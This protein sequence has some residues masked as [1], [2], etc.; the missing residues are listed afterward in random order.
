LLVGLA[1][2]LFLS[3]AL[4]LRAAWIDK[5]ISGLYSP[6]TLNFRTENSALP[7]K[8]KKPRIVLIG[9][10]RISQWPQ[11]LWPQSWE[12]INRGIGGET[13]AQLKA[14]FRSDALALS[15]D[16]VVVESGIN[17]LVAA[18]YLSAS[19]RAE[20]TRK[21]LDALQEFASSGA[22]ARVFVAIATIIPP[23]RPDFVRLF[24]WDDRVRASVTR[25][26]QEL[27]GV[28]HLPP[29]LDFSQL[30][31]AADDAVLPNVYRKD[32]LH[33]NAAGYSLLT[34]A[35]VRL[36]QGRLKPQREGP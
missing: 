25:V 7:L 34:E 36:L 19:Q 27:K 23:A 4:T 32:T 2:A 8:G 18:S 21:T 26:N 10:S 31:H 30:L 22:A 35:T 17:D 15:P 24:I 6:G 14:R 12:V 1:L 3:F 11:D 13:A 9:D 33:L 28:R 16:A 5:K 29:I 20:I